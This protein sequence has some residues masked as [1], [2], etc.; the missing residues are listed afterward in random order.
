MTCLLLLHL[1][2]TPQVCLFAQETGKLFPGIRSSC[3]RHLLAAAHNSIEVGAVFAVLKAILMLGDAGIG[4]N[5]VSSLKS[6]EFHVRGFLDEL[7]EEEIWGSSRALKSCR[8]TISMEA[9]GLSEYGDT[10]QN[11]CQQGKPQ[12]CS[13]SFGERALVIE[14]CNIY[15][16]AKLVLYFG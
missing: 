14:K 9:A 1:F 5:N 10:A 16:G 15:F 2:R 7:N 6:E 3:D 13:S 8:K 4:S 11:I 12:N